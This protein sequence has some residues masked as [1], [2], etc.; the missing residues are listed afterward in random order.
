[1]TDLSL[2]V[3]LCSPPSGALMCLV[4][5]GGVALPPLVQLHLVRLTLII[6]RL[7]QQKSDNYV[8]T[9][10]FSGPV[11]GPFKLVSNWARADLFVLARDTFVASGKETTFVQV[12]R[13]SVKN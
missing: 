7:Q 11:F 1:M 6:R 13:V 9:C 4:E 12:R 8:R 3:H 2:E 10:C 5:T